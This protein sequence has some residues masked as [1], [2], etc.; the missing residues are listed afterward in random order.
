MA[1]AE[2]ERKRAERETAELMVSR[3][4][5]PTRGRETAELHQALKAEKRERAE[6]DAELARRKRAEE[7][8]L[9][10]ERA[11]ALSRDLAA[12][13]ERDI[14]QQ[15]QRFTYSQL[16]EATKQFKDKLGGGGF[17]SVFMG[18]LPSGTQIAVKRLEQDSALGE[19]HGLPGSSQLETEV[20]TLS[21]ASHPNVVPLLG[22]SAD[23]VAPCLVYAAFA[24]AVPSRTVSLTA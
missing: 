23:G 19:A 6:N 21:T 24:R 16:A 13:A 1:R 5:A 14:Q 22:W 18:R 4:R 7:Q 2:A 20:R 8:L 15:A 17:G 10:A 9:A 12:A 3:S 11:E